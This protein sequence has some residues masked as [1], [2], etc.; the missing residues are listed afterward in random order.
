MIRCMVC[1][2]K[3]CRMGQKGC[4]ILG[5]YN[6]LD[7][8]WIMVMTEDGE[9]TKVSLKDVFQHAHTY[10]SLAGDM[11]TQ[12]F[13]VMRV[14]L[15]V[16]HTVFSRVNAAGETYKYLTLDNR[17]VPQ[18]EIEEDDADDYGEELFETWEMLWRTGRFP[19][20]VATYLEAWRDRFYLFDETYP[21]Y[22][23]T[24]ESIAPDKINKA[25]G[26]IICGKNI[27]RLISESANPKKIALFS[28]KD[29]F[30]ENKEV[31]SE[32]EV[33]RWLITYQSYSGLTDKLVFKKGDYKVV[34]GSPGWL[35][36]IGGI[37]INGNNLFQ[38]LWLN[39]MLWHTE[40]SYRIE[41]QCP[42]WE[43][44]G[45]YVISKYLNKKS[46][47]NLAALYT[48]WSRAV[49]ISP[50]IDITK[51]FSLQSVIL[52]KIEYENRFLEPL[53]MWISSKDEKDVFKPKEHNINESFWRSFGL[54][55][56]INKEERYREP[57]IVRWIKR[58]R[59]Y[60]K[61]SCI[62]FSAVG[63]KKGGKSSLWMPIDEIYDELQL[64]Y[65]V[66]ADAD[67]IPRIND[68]VEETKEV[69]ELIYGRFLSEVKDI[70]GFVE[71]QKEKPKEKPKEKQIEKEKQ[72]MYFMVDAP[73]R[74]WLSQL[75]VDAGKEE[76][77]KEWR[78]IL[79]GIVE[80]GA[81]KIWQT[82][83]PRD[84]IG[85]DSGKD[86]KTGSA[87]GIKN[88]ATA[89]RDFRIRLYKKLQ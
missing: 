84:Y 9:N 72:K 7:E 44:T 37:Y 69:I 86:S 3:K 4:D 74:R 24:K 78:E 38:T 27:N 35:F 63:M 39:C 1:N 54:L 33:V 75:T 50:S 15:A 36:D 87:K 48:D 42:C 43:Y 34:E 40:E 11:F 46:I 21:F 57:G 52:P 56:P 70:R 65:E 30:G 64:P 83:G 22:Q 45:E 6:L 41:R 28:P 53:T 18:N 68:A 49:Y 51:G 81:K 32:D 20:I 82:A 80:T 60:V 17:Y 67:W 77:L 10:R 5:R 13:A 12:D 88:I 25:K 31:L 61:S 19:E 23:V 2:M 26:G 71:N 47:T 55:I 59:E 76:A 89:Y 85:I 14:L 73:F 58:L 79:K 16:L 66:I 62:Q 8:P 29:G